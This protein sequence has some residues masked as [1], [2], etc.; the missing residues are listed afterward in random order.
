MGEEHALRIT[1]C[2]GGVA[3]H[4]RRSFVH[5]C[6]HLAALR[7]EQDFITKCLVGSSG[8]SAH[9]DALDMRTAQLADCI[10]CQFSDGRVMEEKFAA[11]MLKDEFD[12][13]CGQ[14]HV[15]RIQHGAERRYREI[16]LEM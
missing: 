14:S 15:D 8:Y 9:H 3:Q 2:A 5:V 4:R 13:S 1:R 7:C 12:V 16:K 10:E 6:P 11:R